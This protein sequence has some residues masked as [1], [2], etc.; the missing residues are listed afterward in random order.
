VFGGAVLTGGA[1]SRMGMDKALLEVDG[2]PM[3]TRVT[4]ALTAAG[5]DPVIAV[6]GDEAGL[7]AIGLE[8]WPDRF[9]GEGPLG[10]VLSAFD[11]LAE[12]ELV[13]AMATDLPRLTEAVVRALASALG[14][15]DAAM[16]STGR[17]E[18]LCALWRRASCAPVLRAAFEDGERAVHRAVVGLDVVEVA[19]APALLRNINN[20]ADLGR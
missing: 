9:P 17:L 1:S 4:A 11:G 2:R 7:R 13:A 18:P 3:A 16:A 19:V 15:H 20:P 8:W 14:R 6:G 10:G 12:C 5:A